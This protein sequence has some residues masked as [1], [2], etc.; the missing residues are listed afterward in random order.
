MAAN[1]TPVSSEDF[2]IFLNNLEFQPVKLFFDF[3]FV[4]TFECRL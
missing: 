2:K 3:N 4:T 1:M